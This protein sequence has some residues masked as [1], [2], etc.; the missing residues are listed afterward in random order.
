[1]FVC[2]SLV[3]CALAIGSTRRSLVRRALGR[4]GSRRLWLVIGVA[5]ESQLVSSPL[6]EIIGRC[7]VKR[8]V[9]LM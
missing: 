4:G 1:L 8:V 2:G 7:I 9:F 5:G 3:V 6:I